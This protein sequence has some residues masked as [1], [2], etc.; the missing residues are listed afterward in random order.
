MNTAAF[1]IS[2]DPQT[3]GYDHIRIHPK[4]STSLGR[5]LCH[6]A[7][8]PFTHP[9]HGRFASMEAYWQWVRTGMKHDGL[10][11][12]YGHRAV[13]YGLRF[14]QVEQKNFRAIILEG[15]EAKIKEHA[16]IKELLVLSDIPFLQY[17]DLVGNGDYIVDHTHDWY[18]DGLHAIRKDWQQK[19]ETKSSKFLPFKTCQLLEETFLG[20]LP[21]DPI[22]L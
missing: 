6:S 20:S 8:T 5:C 12:I 7:R 1:D 15:L 4:A 13:G 9:L 18:L 21:K 10:K 16:K 19:L 11:A 2:V 22:A 14:P 3:D 17:T